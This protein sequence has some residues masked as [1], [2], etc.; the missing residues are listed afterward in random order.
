MEGIDRGGGPKRLIFVDGREQVRVLSRSGKWASDSK[1]IALTAEAA[2]ALDEYEIR[3]DPIC[4]H[5]SLRG[6]AL[7]E[8]QLTLDAYNL[9]Q[10]I[11]EFILQHCPC[12]QSDGPGFLTGQLYYIQYSLLA[13]ATRAFLMREAVRVCRPEA[14]SVFESEID[15]WFYDDGYVHN[16]W[17]GVLEEYAARHGLACERIPVAASRSRMDRHILAFGRRAYQFARRRLRARL[18]RAQTATLGGATSGVQ[19]LRLLFVDSL[20]YDWATVSEQ[21]ASQDVVRMVLR[22]RKLQSR[23]WSYHY[24]PKLSDLKTGAEQEF[25]NAALS[26]DPD[27]TDAIGELFDRWLD[28]RASPPE[29][30][31]LDMNLWPAIVPHLRRMASLGPALVR[32]TDRIAACALDV[33][34]PHAACFNAMQTLAAQ[35]FAHQC[36]LRN[37][38]VVCYQHGGSY[39]AHT[40]AQHEY[41][42]L[43]HADYFLAYGSGVQQTWEASFPARAEFVPMGSA[44]VETMAD[45]VSRRARKLGSPLTVLWVSEVSMRNTV[46]GHFLVE[47]TERYLLQKRCLQLL[48]AAANLRVIFRPHPMHR[49]EQWTGVIAW[50]GRMKYRSIGLSAVKP[51]AE[52]ID[53]SDVVVSDTSSGTVWNEV[54]AMSRPLILYCDPKQTPLAKPFQADL[55]SA[56]HWCKSGE[57]LVAAIGRLV[58]DG[59]AFMQ[60]LNKADASRFIRNYVLHPGDGRCADRVTSFLSAVCRDRKPPD[61]WLQTPSKVC[62]KEGQGSRLVP[63]MSS[64]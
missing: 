17:L 39:G 6:M 13:V 7:L 18:A 31:L 52:L 55:E 61:V 25:A 11:E 64:L 19:G 37:V 53:E 56:C 58:R 24:L 34:R 30:P 27:E 12:A 10:E 48:G 32:Q 54:V 2:D 23:E 59:E 49:Q 47:D 8:R 35:R 21:L 45:G 29:I 46:A 60:E 44:R 20:S 62:V 51:L 41:T 16:P 57:A 14:I 63:G 36:R 33:A 26:P 40:Y 5:V 42:D 28:E 9:V 38:P 1:I 22:G 3:H 50:L 15:E 4:A 43:G